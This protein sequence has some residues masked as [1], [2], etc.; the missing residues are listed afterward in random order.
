MNPALLIKGRGESADSMR[1]SS[2]PISYEDLA[3]AF[4]LLA[5]GKGTLEVFKYKDGD[6]RERRFIKYYYACEDT[7]E[8]FI[9]YGRAR[10]I[11][12]MRPTG[13]VYNLGK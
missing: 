5:D 10:D 9:V 4:A 2:A 11:E 1:T 8:E 6:T 13:V 12:S 7:M 3:D